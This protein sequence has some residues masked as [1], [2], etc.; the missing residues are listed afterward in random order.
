MTEIDTIPKVDLHCHLEGSIS[1]D[2]SYD[3]ISGR[4]LVLPRRVQGKLQ[5]NVDGG[6]L[7]R[8]EFHDLISVE[9]QAEDL[10]DYTGPYFRYLNKAFVSKDA[11][12]TLTAD[13]LRRAS[14]KNVKGL[15]VTFISEYIN[16]RVKCE[17]IDEVLYIISGAVREAGPDVPLYCGMTPL[18]MSDNLM[19]D[20]YI[21]RI[22]EIKNEFDRD[23]LRFL[24]I[25]GVDIGDFDM[26]YFQITSEQEKA[27]LK[28]I[29]LLKGH[30]F[31]I[32]CHAGEGFIQIIDG[33]EVATPRRLGTLESVRKAISLGVERIGHG[34]AAATDPHLLD[35]INDRGIHIELCPISN[36]KANLYNDYLSEYPIK[37]LMAHGV[38]FSI[39]SDNTTICR[40]TW[41][42]DMQW[43][44]EKFGVSMVDLKKIQEDALRHSFIQKARTISF[45]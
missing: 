21:K 39:N 1:E 4:E 42:D 23:P 22:I 45:L 13:M 12:S 40:S 30:Q 26:D 35:E 2:L 7:T 18:L 31:G 25:V 9:E 38:S 6:A 24:P 43:A 28:N 8:K 15:E 3:I 5:K 17:T 32:K 44:F 29:E 33:K 27:I 41:G 10:I 19:D 14:Q 20:A 37:K 11:L 16:R 34:L 36:Y